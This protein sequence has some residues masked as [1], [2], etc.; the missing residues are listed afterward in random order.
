[1]KTLKRLLSLCFVLLMS[2]FIGFAQPEVM[3]PDP[4]KDYKPQEFI[5]DN[6]HP[7]WREYAKKCTIRLFYFEYYRTC[8]IYFECDY[9]LF[10]EGEAENTCYRV[11][12]DFAQA[13]GYRR[14]PVV[15]PVPIKGPRKV[16]GMGI[17]RW[18]AEI[19]FSD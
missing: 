15:R 18:E 1:M 7:E 10:E 4:A 11:I 5:Y 6:Y 2:S 17:Q 14:K 19:I 12:E 9:S 3:G 16:N 13:H 8:R